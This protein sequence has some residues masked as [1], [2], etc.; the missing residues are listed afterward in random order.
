M[1]DFFRAFN[2]ERECGPLIHLCRFSFTVN[3]GGYFWNRKYRLIDK[4]VVV[5]SAGESVFF[6]LALWVEAL[7]IKYVSA[8]ETR[9]IYRAGTSRVLF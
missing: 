6:E 1:T 4:S 3:V 2:F 5:C 9:M 8:T 7:A